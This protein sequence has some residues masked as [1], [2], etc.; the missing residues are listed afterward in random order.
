MRRNK[1]DLF[2]KIEDDLRKIIS[3]NTSVDTSAIDDKKLEERTRS[4]IRTLL[5]SIL[6]NN[7][8]DNSAFIEMINPHLS[9]PDFKKAINDYLLKPDYNNDKVITELILKINE[10]NQEK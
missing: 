3:N 5:F 9:N 1:N 6:K 7:R 4:L 10:K 2:E 8:Y